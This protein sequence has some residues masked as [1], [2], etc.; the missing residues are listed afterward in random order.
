M[1]DF[2]A[3]YFRAKERAVKLDSKLQ[4]GDKR[5]SGSVLVM[6][7]DGSV[8]LFD[9]A[10]VLIWVRKQ[11]DEDYHFAIVLTEHHGPHVYPMGELKH[12]RAIGPRLQIKNVR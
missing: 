9:R 5:L 11:P 1:G 10:F 6:H 3:A 7:R 2:E 4:A 8:F 12:L